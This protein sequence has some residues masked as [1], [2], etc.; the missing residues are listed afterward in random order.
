MGTAPN[1]TRKRHLLWESTSIIR[2][3]KERADG[4]GREG[5]E[6]VEK[7]MVKEVRDGEHSDREVRRNK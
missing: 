2:I 5:G 6:R 7:E 3:R 1:G 4:E